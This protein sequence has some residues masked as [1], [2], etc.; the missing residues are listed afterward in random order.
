MSTVYKSMLCE[1]KPKYITTEHH[2][3]KITC[4]KD[5]YKEMLMHFDTDTL[6]YQ[7]EVV[8]LYLNRANNTIGM[9]KLSKGGIAGSVVDGK[10][11]YS[12]ALQ[13]GAS[14]IILAHNHPSGNIKPSDS[15]LK[16]TANL[17]QF[18]KLID[19]SLIDH[20]IISNNKF[21]SLADKGLI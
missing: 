9:Q 10:I 15:D 19:I 3:V 8:V 21:F 13:T 6:E 5:A 16:L 2:R 11:L 1:V 17:K 7:E 12:M 14:G 18:G 4:A 20:L